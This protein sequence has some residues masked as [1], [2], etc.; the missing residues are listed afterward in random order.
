[1]AHVEDD[2][3]DAALA[4]IQVTIGADL[5]AVSL[6]GSAVSGALR[7]DSD[8][9]LLVLTARRIGTDAKRGLVD[10]LLPISG[11]ETRPDGWRP[12]EVTVVALPDVRPWRYPPRK[13]LQ[14]GEWLRAAFLAGA[15]EPEPAESP[16]LAVLLTMARR[17]SR[18]LHGPSLARTLEEVPAPDLARALADALPSLLDDLEDDTRNVLLTLARMWFTLET[19]QIGSKDAAA[20]WALA[21]LPAAHRPLLRRARDLYRDGGFGRWAAELPHV[22]ALAEDF[23]ERIRAAAG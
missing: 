17:D 23:A 7:P 12:L 15:I 18:P 11:R 22:R 16:D 8:L 1:M 3:L 9:D 14:Y 4:A 2:Q 19:G 21:R 6:Y 13:E 20:D 5:V 10:A